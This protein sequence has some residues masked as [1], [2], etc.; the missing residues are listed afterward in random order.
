M[1]FGLDRRNFLQR[2]LDRRPFGKQSAI[3]ASASTWAFGAFV[4]NASAYGCDSLVDLI[5]DPLVYS[6]S[7]DESWYSAAGGNIDEAL[8]DYAAGIGDDIGLKDYAP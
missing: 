7:F 4:A 6:E 1:R 5:P 2:V 3:P 8:K